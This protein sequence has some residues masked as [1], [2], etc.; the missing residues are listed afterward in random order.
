MNPFR[1]HTIEQ[2]CEKWDFVTYW[3]L[4]LQK[5][6]LVLYVKLI[7][8]RKGYLLVSMQGYQLKRASIVSRL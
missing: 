1:G 4:V 8:A 6:N 5:V 2:Q 7:I 3:I